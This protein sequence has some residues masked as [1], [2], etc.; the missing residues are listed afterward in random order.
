M[1]LILDACRVR[2]REGD[3]IRKSGSVTGMNEYMDL[4]FQDRFC[5]PFDQKTPKEARKANRV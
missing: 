2:L 4:E 5:A 1:E 3:D